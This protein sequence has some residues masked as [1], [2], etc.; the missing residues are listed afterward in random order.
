M[1]LD[2][3]ELTLF[4]MSMSV[5]EENEDDMSKKLRSLPFPGSPGVSYKTKKLEVDR[6]PGL[7]NMRNQLT[8]YRNPPPSPLPPLPPS[9][10]R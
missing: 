5:D 9:P 3:F 2:L 7:P 4:S 6:Y 10:P 1:L 8:L